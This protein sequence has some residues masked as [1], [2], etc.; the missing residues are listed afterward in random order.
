MD[1]CCVFRSYLILHNTNDNSD[2]T[3]ITAA[4]AAARKAELHAPVFADGVAGA[5]RKFWQKGPTVEDEAPLRRI[6]QPDG[7][8]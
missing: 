7:Q 5:L 1:L 4:V 3:Q 6:K 8:Q 2:N